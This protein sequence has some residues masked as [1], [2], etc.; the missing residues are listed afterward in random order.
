[1]GGGGT[2]QLWPSSE[3]DYDPFLKTF[4][5][6]RR[7]KFSKRQE[8]EWGINIRIKEDKM[9]IHKFNRTDRDEKQA[10]EASR[11]IC[12]G[13]AILAIGKHRFE[14]HGFRGA[15]A[16]TQK[17]LAKLGEMLRETP[18]DLTLTVRSR[19]VVKKRLN[20]RN[21]MVEGINKH[22]QGKKV[23]QRGMDLTEMASLSKWDRSLTN[24]ARGSYNSVKN[25]CIF[26][27]S[28]LSRIGPYG[29][30]R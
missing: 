11:K 17:D 12:P 20:H 2:K 18:T 25:E 10:I 22:R 14:R 19:I 21:K 4:R 5:P 30:H 26:S 8:E 13:D 27:Y 15:V 29:K 7:F 28:R 23:K 3:D 6:E 24:M 9:C 1:M 16:A